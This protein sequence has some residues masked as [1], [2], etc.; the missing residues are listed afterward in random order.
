DKWLMEEFPNADPR[1]RSLKL[2]TADKFS[3]EARFSG[4]DAEVLHGLSEQAK[5]IFAVH[6]D[7][8]YVRDDWRQKSKV[9][10]PVINQEKMRTA[11]I[12]RA[13]I[14]FA[15]KRASEGMPLGR[16]L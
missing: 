13:D 11:G 14:A 7:T 2:A 3:V 12:N 4:P 5:A 6:P 1:F 9:F 16:M 8:K 15:M 10:E